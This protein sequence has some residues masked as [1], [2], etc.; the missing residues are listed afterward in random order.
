MPRCSGW[1]KPRHAETQG[2]RHRFVYAIAQHDFGDPAGAIE[3]LRRLHARLPADEQVLTALLNY[4]A[5]TGNMA[6][7]KRYAQKLLRIAPT[8]PGYQ[9]MARQLG[10]S[11]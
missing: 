4:S 1:A 9:Q 10:V 8:N 5:E 7:A 11:G 6:A 3:T 2:S